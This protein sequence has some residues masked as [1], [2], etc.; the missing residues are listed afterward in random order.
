MRVLQPEEGKYL[1]QA[2][3][4]DIMERIITSDK[5]YLAAN[6]NVS[7]WIE[8]DFAKAENYNIMKR[9][10]EEELEKNQE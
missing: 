4:V 7:D 10:A 3:D 9:S 5:I 6:A 1:T 8:I 2:N